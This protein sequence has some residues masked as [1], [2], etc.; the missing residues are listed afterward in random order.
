MSEHKEPEYISFTDAAKLIVRRGYAGSMT[1]QGLRYMARN[2]QNRA[3][4]PWP[5]GDRPGQ[6]PYL[7]AGRTRMMRTAL[8]LEYLEK[9]PPIGRG[10][11]KEPT[12]RQR[13]AE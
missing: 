5:F 8:L 11:N 2:R 9:H 6:E 12:E 7:I 1:S 3:K 10:P 13:A 4:G